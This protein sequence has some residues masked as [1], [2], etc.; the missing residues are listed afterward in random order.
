[1]F[2]YSL[3]E[4]DSFPVIPDGESIGN[5]TPSAPEGGGTDGSQQ[6]SSIGYESPDS[7]PPADLPIPPPV[8]Q[9]HSN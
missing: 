3:Q 7:T 9:P 5:T 4:D 1:M 8:E 6:P 2:D